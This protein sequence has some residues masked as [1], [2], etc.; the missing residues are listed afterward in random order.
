MTSAGLGRATAGTVS[1]GM[2]SEATDTVSSRDDSLT[3]SR[4]TSRPALASF[5]A[6]RG[7]EPDPMALLR[8]YGL[9]A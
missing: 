9:A 3:E 2:P 5:V 1:K 6:F 8:S 4:T 7:R